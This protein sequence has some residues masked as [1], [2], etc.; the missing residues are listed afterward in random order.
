M[1]KI[2]IEAVLFPSMFAFMTGIMVAGALAN[3]GQCTCVALDC[4]ARRTNFSV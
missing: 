1:L 2:V 3:L 4:A